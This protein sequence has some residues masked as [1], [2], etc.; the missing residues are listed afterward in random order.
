[1]FCCLSVFVNINLSSSYLLQRY[2]SFLLNL[3]FFCRFFSLTSSTAQ[4]T[5]WAFSVAWQWFWL[6]FLYRPLHLNFKCDSSH[7]FP[8][9]NNS[10]NYLFI[11]SYRFSSFCVS[12]PCLELTSVVFPRLY[13]FRKLHQGLNLWVFHSLWIFLLAPFLS[14]ITSLAIWASGPLRFTLSLSNFSCAIFYS[15]VKQW[16]YLLSSSFHYFQMNN[17][18]RFSPD[19]PLCVDRVLHKYL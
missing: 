14:H 18:W 11:Y 4:P 19:V 5:C 12:V 7:L 6:D 2:W 15:P 10:Q 8:C 3:S 17:L 9:N 1:M 16:Q 13:C